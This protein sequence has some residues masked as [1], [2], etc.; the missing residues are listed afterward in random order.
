MV[1]YMEKTV[2]L[3]SGRVS[4]KEPDLDILGEVND[5]RHAFHARHGEQLP[6]LPAA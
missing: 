1:V 5:D 2:G 6:S 4:M 3:Q